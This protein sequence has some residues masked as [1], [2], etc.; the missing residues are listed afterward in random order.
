MAFYITTPLY[1]VN[2]I[3][4]IGHAYCTVMCD[5][6]N[7]YH[8]LFGEETLMLTGTDEHGQKCEQAASAKGITPQ[9]HCDSMAPNFKKVWDEFNIS[10]DIFFRT[11]D[12][13]HKE[14]VQKAL[15]DLF[16]K[17][18]IYE[19]TYEGWYS[20]SEE[21]FYTEKEIVD[22]KSPTGKPVSKISEKNYFFKMSKYQERLIKHINDNPGFIKPESRK[23]EVLGFLKKD[24]TDLCIS[25][26]KERMGWGIE[27]PFDKDYVTYVWF[28][29]LL[30]YA[31]GIGYNQKEKS[32][33]FKKWWPVA[34]HVV[35]K[36]ILTTH[37]VYWTTMLMALEVPLP[38]SIFA[39]G[40]LLNKSNEKMSK[41][42]GDVINPMDFKD[43]VD[44]D[45]LRYYFARDIHFGNDSPISKD[46]IFNRLNNELSNNLGNLLSRTTNLITKFYDGKLVKKINTSDETVK[47]LMALCKDLPELV[48]KDINDFKPS[49]AIEHIINVLNEC[50]RYLEETAPW[51]LAKT[52]TD[53]A[54]EVLYV[55]LE[56]LRICSG[57][58]YPVMPSKVI[59]L[60]ETLGLKE[61]TWDKL[62]QFDVLTD[63]QSISKA[64]PLFP[65]LQ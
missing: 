22:G 21:I 39:H 8:K 44:I 15:Q 61:V 55:A 60:Y 35:G 41:S 5:I 9:A 30:N 17:G 6:L 31:T 29:A 25:R 65:R 12:N 52:D 51:K 34:N 7:R 45:P 43:I 57:L 23:N 54:A 59:A 24:L 38:K 47:K 56:I 64:T 27:I 20:V 11:T 63:G 36:D 40:W 19:A 37:A 42:E 3:P 18:E 46:I 53:A 32:E 26:P 28:D 2:D 62:C 48:K 4:H 58:L 10:Y 14:S 1:Y 33:A 50:N 49:Y 13:F 16:D